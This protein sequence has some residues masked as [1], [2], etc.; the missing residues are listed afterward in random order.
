MKLKSARQTAVL[1]AKYSKIIQPPNT[2]IQYFHDEEYR[3]VGKM[4]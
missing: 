3:T 2:P 4:S 1:E